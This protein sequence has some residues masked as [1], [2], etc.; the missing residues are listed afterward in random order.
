ME[1]KQ[2]ARSDMTVVYRI[3]G[4]QYVALQ[5]G[6]DDGFV[7]VGD[8]T[9]DGRDDLVVETETLIETV[10]VFGPNGKPRYKFQL[11]AGYNHPLL[12]DI[13]GDG[14]EELINLEGAELAAYHYEDKRTT[15][16]GWPYERWLPT[17]AADLDGDGVDE[18]I[19][20]FSELKVKEIPFAPEEEKILM[21]PLDVS[22]KLVA[23]WTAERAR[24]RGG[25]LNP[26]TG[27]VV[28]F[29]FP[30]T[31]YRYSI[32]LGLPEEVAAF[33]IDGD[34]QREIIT[35]AAL[36]SHI[37]AFNQAGEAAYHEEFSRTALTMGVAR[38]E[39]RDYLVLQ[40]DDRLLVYP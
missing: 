16:P 24:P 3:T 22:D 14:A 29:E 20:V 4:M 19:S 31:N 17:G 12:A 26:A 38:G 30:E 5:D 35:K 36:G 27:D 34:G 40:L 1:G 39:D 2:V 21:P 25:Y 13:D 23:I 8:F 33:D 11:D 28:E 10:R 7:F 9:G 18:V 6:D 37:L 32:Y 15:V